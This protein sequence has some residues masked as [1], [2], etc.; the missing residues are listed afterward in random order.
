MPLPHSYQTLV[1]GILFT[2][3]FVYIR[4]TS[5]KTIIRRL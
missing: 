3:A 2:W 5:D 1:V 4:F